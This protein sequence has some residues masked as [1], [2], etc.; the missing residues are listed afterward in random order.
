ML[1]S[2]TVRLVSQVGAKSHHNEIRLVGKGQ[3]EDR[4]P[5]SNWVKSKDVRL[6]VS[7]TCRFLGCWCHFPPGKN[8]NGAV[9]PLA[10]SPLD[11]FLGEAHPAGG[12]GKVRWGRR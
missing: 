2:G 12:R 11:C 5:Q 3:Q 1:C 4:F 9:T 7:G 6:S 8:E 10:L